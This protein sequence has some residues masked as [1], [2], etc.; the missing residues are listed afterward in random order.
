MN[1]NYF[2]LDSFVIFQT[3]CFTWSKQWFNLVALHRVNTICNCRNSNKSPIYSL[4]VYITNEISW[5][6]NHSDWIRWPFFIGIGHEEAKA[7]LEHEMDNWLNAQ[8]TFK[9]NLNFINSHLIQLKISLNAHTFPSKVGSSKVVQP[10]ILNEKENT[11]R[12]EHEIKL[13]TRQ[14]ISIRCYGQTTKEPIRILL[15]IQNTSWLISNE[16]QNWIT[17]I[18]YSVELALTADKLTA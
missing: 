13:L 12:I 17:I 15:T 7:S 6:W 16:H 14:T 1:S 2:L 3:S 11:I 8:L 10:Q 5:Y 4:L 9:L 18:N